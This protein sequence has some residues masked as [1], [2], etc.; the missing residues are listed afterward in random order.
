M[1]KITDIIKWFFN[2]VISTKMKD[3]SITNILICNVNYFAYKRKNT[4][5]QRSNR[6]DYA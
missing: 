1:G 2:L 6:K 5:V 4:H 3:L